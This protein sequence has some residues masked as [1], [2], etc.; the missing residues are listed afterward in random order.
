MKGCKVYVAARKS[1]KTLN[2]IKA[3]QEHLGEKGS[4][5]LHH[6]LDLGSISTS[7]Q[8]A[9]EFRKLE[10][11]LDILVANAGISMASL[12]E[13]SPDG[14]E[15][16]FAVNHLGHFAFI[17]NLLGKLSANSELHT[18]KTQ[19]KTSSKPLLQVK[20]KHASS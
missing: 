15:K 5:V 7:K 17:T 19:D 11:R 13:L 2:G 1:E 14:F 8:S 10:S 16:M 9:L 6:D 18:A 4:L 12:A 20:A 3:I